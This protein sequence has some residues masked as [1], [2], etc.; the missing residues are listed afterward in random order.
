MTLNDVFMTIKVG[1]DEK[2][3]FATEIKCSSDAVRLHPALHDITLELTNCLMLCL[4]GD[5][6]RMGHE[7]DWEMVRPGDLK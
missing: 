4:K 5:L 6:Y 2:E 7:I 1:F 3:S